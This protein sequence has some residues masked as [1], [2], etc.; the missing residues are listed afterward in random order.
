MLKFWKEKQA[1]KVGN[2]VCPVREYIGALTFHPLT[3]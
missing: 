2:N 3:I 1:N